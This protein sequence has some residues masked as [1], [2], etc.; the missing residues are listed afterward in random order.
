MG[1]RDTCS[2]FQEIRC[3]FGLTYLPI[4][5]FKYFNARRHCLFCQY[6]HVQNTSF[7]RVNVIKMVHHSPELTQALCNVVKENVFSST[8]SSSAPSSSSIIAP[9]S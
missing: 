7:R 3:D 6:L 9:I 8:S 4:Y 1:G 2:Y 5:A